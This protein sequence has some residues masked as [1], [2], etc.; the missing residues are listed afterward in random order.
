MSEKTNDR[1]FAL[2]VTL[3]GLCGVMLG[4]ACLL[5]FGDAPLISAYHGRSRISGLN[6]LIA[7]HRLTH[8]AATLDDYLI[9]GRLVFSRLLVVWVA[10]HA[11]ILIGLMHRQVARGLRTFFSAEGPALNLAVFRIVVFYTIWRFIGISEVV[12]FSQV[13]PEL[14]VAPAGVGWLMGYL[15]INPLCTRVAA[16]LF[17]GFSFTAM[18]GFCTGTSATVTTLLGLYVLGLPQFFGKV[19]HY[20]HLLWFSAL[21]AASRCGDS[22]S[23]DALISAWRKSARGVVDPPARSSVY[24]LPLRYVWLLMGLIYFFAG[25]WK[26]WAGGVDWVLSDNLKYIMYHKWTQM[27]GWTPFFRVDRYPVLYRSAALATIGF[28][29]SFVFLLL[30]SRLRLLA[31]F[32]GLLFHRLTEVFMRIS[33]GALVSCYVAFF[34]WNAILLRIGRWLFKDEMQ[35]V[36]N[37]GSVRVRRLIGLVQAFDILGRVTYLPEADGKPMSPGN[38]GAALLAT[39]DAAGL[40]GMTRNRVWS[41]VSSLRALAWRVPACWLVLPFLYVLPVQRLEHRLNRF[42]AGSRQ[43]TPISGSWSSDCIVPQVSLRAVMITGTLLL[44][45]ETIAGLSRAVSA[46]PLAC[47]PTFAVVRRKPQ[48][49]FSELSMRTAAGDTILLSRSTIGVDL[50][51]TRLLGLTGQV[52]TAQTEPQRRALGRALWRLWA[53][54]N[55]RLRQAGWIIVHRLTLS[56]VPEEWHANPKRRELLFEAPL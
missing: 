47:Y 6:T 43:S 56:T 1:D 31:V 26:L 19:N 50:E 25:A 16:V 17:F 15:P 46:W 36:Y 53:Q 52:L 2:I 35:L 28:E 23:C 40:T 49:A 27:G 37:A 24:A 3:V 30:S 55:P 22:L 34:D 38:Q 12:W 32:G 29:I 4:L 45:G 18:I 51:S 33:F 8:T 20:H 41:G 7:H 13:P 39:A 14:R 9:D 5:F 21:L 48:A 10:G 42:W 11:I 54:R 44:A